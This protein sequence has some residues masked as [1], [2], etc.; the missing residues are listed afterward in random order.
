MDLSCPTPTAKSCPSQILES[1]S[2]ADGGLKTAQVAFVAAI[3]VPAVGYRVLS[4]RTGK[5]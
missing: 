3:D 5:G 4:R 1:T 2:Y